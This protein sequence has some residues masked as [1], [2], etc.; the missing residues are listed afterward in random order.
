MAEQDNR[1]GA[2]P[3]ILVVLPDGQEVT[4]R[5]HGRR[6]TPQGWW[7]RVGVPAWR[8]TP[9][10]GVEASEY[11]VWVKA[12]DMV[13]P[14]DGAAYD[15][16]PTQRMEPPTAVEQILGPRRPSGWILQKT[17]G[18][19]GPA[20]PVI[21]APDCD[22]APDGGQVLGLEAALTAAERAGVRLCALCGAAQELDRLLGTGQ[23][24]DSA[25]AP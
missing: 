18:R 14:V 3:P 5:L 24:D 1:A 7:Y 22:E 2:A 17:G 23:R 6:Q 10:G 12:P 11:P 21:H 16:V 20:Q 4:G 8:N 25:S 19:R 9:S 13:K 15:A